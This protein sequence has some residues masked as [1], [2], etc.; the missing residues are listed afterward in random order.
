MDA[1]VAVPL[2]IGAGY[3]LG[4]THKFR[5]AVIL[6]SAAATGGLSGLPAQALQRG[7][8]VMQSTPE[9]A[10]MADSA[11]KLLEAGR[12]AVMTAMSSR[13]ESM[14]QALEGR[15]QD[16]SGGAVAGGRGVVEKARPSRRTAGQRS[17]EEPDKD[18]EEAYDE[19]DR[20]DQE[21]DDELDE[22]ED[23]YEDEEQDEA[24]EEDE[25]EAEQPVSRGRRPSGA[26]GRGSAVRRARG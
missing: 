6:G 20:D 1:K 15:A 19:Q 10:K 5:W 25:A 14:G 16:L 4:R 8:Q 18:D 9:L 26:Q 13:V 12:G 23:Q 21:Q 17:T 3:F 22:S 11:Q 24:E 7:T 2:A